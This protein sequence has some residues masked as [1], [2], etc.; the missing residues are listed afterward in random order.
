MWGA[1]K[2]VRGGWGIGG[3]RRRE[4]PHSPNR[5]PGRPTIGRCAHAN[6]ANRTALMAQQATMPRRPS[7]GE[8]RGTAQGPLRTAMQDD[9]RST[10]HSRRRRRRRRR[11]NTA[12]HGPTDEATR[13]GPTAEPTTMSQRTLRREERVTVQGPVRKP[14]KDGMPHGGSMVPQHVPLS[15]VPTTR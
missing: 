2:P 4:D 11:P 7:C 8:D 12:P 15:I 1:N 9:P 3:S 10:S 6:D 14:T 5:S 13:A